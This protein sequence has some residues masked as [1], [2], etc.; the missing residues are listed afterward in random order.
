VINDVLLG[1]GPLVGVV[2]IAL[3]AGAR[4]HA[5]RA[6]AECSDLVQ[7]SVGSRGTVD[8]RA[9]RD[10]AIVRY[11]ALNEMTGQLSFSVAP[12]GRRAWAPAARDV[13]AGS[14]REPG[15]GRD[16]PGSDVR[17]VTRR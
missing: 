5:A 1:L 7:G 8:P 13:R 10:L 6:V 2:G 9:L 11:D 16:A 12:S 4:R 17:M 3:A 15:P 14:G